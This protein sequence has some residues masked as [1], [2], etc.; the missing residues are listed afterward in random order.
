MKATIFHGP[1]DVRVESFPDPRIGAPNEA[2]VRITR[3]A[4]C[5]SDLH[6]YHGRDEVIPGFVLGH[7]AIGIVEETGPAVSRIKKGQRV[8]ISC[9]VSCGDCFFCRRGQPSQCSETGSAVFGFGKNFAGKLGE[10]GGC[11]SEAISV[12]FADYTLYPLPDSITDE[13]AVFLADILPTGFYGALNGDIRPG[14]TVA[15]YGCGPVGLCAVMTA[16]LFGP[17][18]IIAIDSVPHRLELAKKLGATAV[19]VSEASNTIMERTNG[20]GADVC[21][22]A[23]GSE[24]ALNDAFVSVRGGGTVSMIGVV[25]L[26]TFAY[27]MQLAFFK[28]L[29]FRVGLAN[30]RNNIPHL[31]RLIEKGRLD[32]TPL[33]SHVLPLAD[34]P[35]GY[36]IFDA[37]SEGALK[38][39]IKP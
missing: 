31:A 9:V 29:T 15:I 35:R 12:P 36:Q 38:V 20:R 14:D 25:G 32:P 28:G 4:I 13:Q 21:I 37:K 1:R 34:T 6:S 33:V 3:A 27:P 5:G 22:E 26:P 16:G 19:N 2:I 24:A 18:E 39:L 10:V 17:S 30:M 23:V 8:V 11:Q 7:E